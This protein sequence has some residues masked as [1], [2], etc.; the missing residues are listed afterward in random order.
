MEEEEEEMKEER[1][2]GK[3]T[4]TKWRQ[5]Y[6]YVNYNYNRE[7]EEENPIQR[8]E[9][10]FWHILNQEKQDIE[11]REKKRQDALLPKHQPTPIPEEAG[12]TNQSE[13]NNKV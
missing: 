7:D 2:E 13:D 6:F 9:D 5:I 4:P 8:A 11:K 10:D 3:E 12:E 1:E